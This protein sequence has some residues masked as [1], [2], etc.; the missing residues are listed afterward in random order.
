MRC[1]RRKVKEERL[2]RRDRLAIANPVDGL[3]G[4]I[5]HEVVALFGGFAGLHRDGVLE[6]HR[7]ILV[8]LP[9]DEAVEVVEPHARWPTIER[10][11][12]TALP[13]GR[14]VVLT[15]PRCVITVAL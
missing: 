8:R 5:G 2:L 4:H 13:V 9:A 11:G 1:A 10:A 6:Q 15:E 12:D 3:V 7:I 14:V